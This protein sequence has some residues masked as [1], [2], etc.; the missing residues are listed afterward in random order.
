MSSAISRFTTSLLAGAQENTLALAALNFDFS[1]YKVEAPLEY[2]ALGSCLSRERRQ[3]AESGAQHVTARR[4]GALF[5]SEMPS[6]PNLI[7]AYG[8]RVS[9]IAQAPVDQRLLQTEG[10]FADKIGIDG[11]TIWA[12][13]TS[14]S[15]AQGMQLL[16]C[17]LARFWS[18]QEAVSIWAEIVEERKAILKK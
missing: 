14:G 16:A 1:L 13:A 7:K 6:V 11:T 10:I 17:M 4:L 3:N 8:Y 9:Q 12:A 15:E 5:R 18:A 2:Q